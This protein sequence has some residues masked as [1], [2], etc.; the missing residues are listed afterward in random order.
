M[1]KKIFAIIIPLFYM[2]PV[3]AQTSKADSLWKVLKLEL[4]TEN[5][6]IRQKEQKI[7]E[8]RK[9]LSAVPA[10]RYL[11]RYKLLS[12]LFNEYSAFRFDSAITN[13]NKLIALSKQ[14][15][16]NEYLV[17]S[18]MGLA[19][20][21][22]KSGFYK[23]AFETISEIDTIGLSEKFRYDYLNLR[24]MLFDEIAAYNKD[25]YYA[26]GYR[27]LARK[28]FE[29]AQ[30]LINPSEL[31][32]TINLAFSHG[33]GQNKQPD[34]AFYYQYL[35]HHDLSEHQIA[36]IATRISHA[37]SGEDK[38]ML[39]TLAAINDIRSATKET[40]AIFLL[41]QELFKMN[42]NDDAYVCMQEALD[43]AAF[44]GTRNRA[45]QIE[46][47]LP[48]IASRLI[49]EKQHEKEMLWIGIVLFILVAIVLLFQLVLFRKQ[50]IRI[51]QNDL[52]ITEKNTELEDVNGKL[53]ES[54]RIKEELIGLFFKTCSSYI[55]T[56]DKV[57]RK[58]QHNIKLGKYQ[59]AT[60]VLGGVHI[61]KEKIQLFSTLDSV[62]L[63][64]FPN[65][66]S[67]FNALL[68]ADE[69][70]ELKEGEMLTASL[71][72]FALIRLGVT[73]TETIARILDYTVNT[74]Y[75]YKARMKAKALVPPEQFEQ[76][77]MEIKFTDE[78]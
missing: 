26:T 1:I 78:R 59:D 15:S 76:K 58:A 31:E 7:G 6:Y 60:Q 48:L 72:I 20:V 74:V 14:L 9:R 4:S 66:V 10:A 16:G 70:I 41:G 61:Q 67:S 23:E 33:S 43:N 30:S 25:A 3:Y 11:E 32:K 77:I 40:F 73:D 36:I 38:L 13:A 71:R 34:V 51:E 46:S 18:Q 62:F 75:T 68:R 22:V 64:L 17:Q 39:L 27:K 28:E 53:W 5:H 8:M 24:G 52:I 69:Q 35:L 19:T 57:K 29:K 45:A 54:S 47:V 2:V 63:A 42:R 12:G 21:L 65:F 49:E 55:E 50:M 56:L 37:Y 44:Y